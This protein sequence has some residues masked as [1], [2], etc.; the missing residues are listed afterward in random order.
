MPVKVSDKT[1]PMPGEAGHKAMTGTEMAAVEDTFKVDALTL[2]TDR[3]A[4][5]AKGYTK[6]RLIYSLAWIA[7]LRAENNGMTLTAFMDAFTLDDIELF[8][9]ENPTEATLPVAE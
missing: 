5:P 6:L 4:D 9:D 2:L 1:Y 7:Y 8:D 3:N